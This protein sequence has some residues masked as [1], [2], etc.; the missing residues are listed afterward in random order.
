[1]ARK[2]SGW[3]SLSKS[4]GEELCNGY[5]RSHEV[6]V[7][8]LRFCYVSGA[9][10]IVDYEQFYLSELKELRPELKSLW[11]GEERLVVLSDQNGRL[12][13]KHLADV[14]DIVHGCLCALGKQAAIGETFQLAGPKPFTWDEAVNRLATHLEIPVVEASIGPPATF[15]EYDLS[16]PRELLGF[17]PEYD[18][19]RMIDDA[20]AFRSGEQLDLL[21]TD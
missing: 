15:Y 6:P 2:P 16:K 17:D 19:V 8:V 3:Y 5:F 10:E 1:M 13:K 12:H 14:R 21:P 20:M 7:T 11:E 18:I 4:M 9:G